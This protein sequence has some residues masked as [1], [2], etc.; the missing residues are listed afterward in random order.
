[1]TENILMELPGLLPS[2]DQEIEQDLFACCLKIILALLKSSNE[3]RNGFLFWKRFQSMMDVLRFNSSASIS[4]LY[5]S[6]V[7]PEK[8]AVVTS[9][10]EVGSGK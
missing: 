5:S 1:M 10:L 8:F 6:R 4:A 9:Q 3:S 7:L 2:H